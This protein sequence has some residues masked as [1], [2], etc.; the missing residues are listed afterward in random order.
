MEPGENVPNGGGDTCWYFEPSAALS[1][2]HDWV[3]RDGLTIVYNQRLDRT[4]EP[5]AT[6]RGDG[7]YLISK[8]GKTAGGVTVV[9]GRI[10]SITME[11][12]M[13]FPG[14]CSSTRHTRAT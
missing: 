3:E 10:T 14:K 9:D 13:F 1:V 4:G 8:T 5:K 12:G 11:S 6:D 7:Y 2:Y